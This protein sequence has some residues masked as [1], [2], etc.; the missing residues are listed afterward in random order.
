MSQ[1]S[2]FELSSWDISSQKVAL[3]I[4][5]REQVYTSF[6]QSYGELVKTSTKA[7]LNIVTIPD[8]STIL[9]NQRNDLAQAAID[10]GA[11]WILWLDSDMIFPST[12]LLRLL[13]HKRPLIAGNYMKRSLPLTTVAYPQIGD[14]ENWLP[15]EMQGDTEVV[16]GVGMGVFLMKTSILEE[17]PRP[18]FNFEY[19]DG[20][21]HGEDFYFQQLLRNAGYEIHIDMNLSR[22]IHHCG[23]W[24]YGHSIGTNQDQ[25]LKRIHLSENS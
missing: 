23:L 19:R 3:C 18:W 6:M 25:I 16:E 10:C 12:T 4:P 20:R 11:D 14:W 9:L 17:L 7:G 22:Q 8:A 24:A 5:C 21:Y 15:L 2:V 13:A 1:K